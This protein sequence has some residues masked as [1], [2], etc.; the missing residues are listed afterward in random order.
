MVVFG[1]VVSYLIFAFAL[2]ELTAARVSAFSYLA[3]LITTVLGAWWLAEKLTSRTVLCGV[4]ILVGVYLTERGRDNGE[5]A[6]KP[7]RTAP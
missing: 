5:A 7:E 4:M 1:S 3:P 2:T 6:E